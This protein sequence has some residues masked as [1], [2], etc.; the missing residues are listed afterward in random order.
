MI[1]RRTFSDIGGGCQ[2]TGQVRGGER[3]SFLKGLEKLWSCYFN[4][5]RRE[6]LMK[7]GIIGSG[8]VAQ[9]LGSG[10]IKHGHEVMLGARTISK[11]SEWVSQNPWGRVGSPAEAA[12]FGESAVL[13]VKGTAALDA[14]HDTVGLNLRGKPVV[15]A[16]NPIADLPPE[17]GVLRFFTTGEES[18]MERLQREHPDIH[19]VKAFNSVG[20]ACMV[21]P[22]FNK[23]SKPTM[24]ICGNDVAAK[25]I[26]SDMCVQF[27]WETEDLGKAEAAR[28]IEPLCMLWCIP[29][30]LHNDWWHAFKL[31]R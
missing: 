29:G 19:F 13:A 1:F 3:G 28:A 27:G 14:L 16:T 25:K 23:G 31:L 18:L 26:V 21:N 7:I 15:D 9:T 24:F 22:S 12:A 20:H 11:L 4:R 17:N 2:F 6:V 5:F 8:A 30:L 10:F